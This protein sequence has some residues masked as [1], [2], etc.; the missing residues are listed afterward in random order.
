MIIEHYIRNAISILRQNTFKKHVNKS[1]FR[2]YR[3]VSSFKPPIYA[4]N[5]GWW[6][7]NGIFSQWT[8]SMCFDS[9]YTTPWIPSGFS[10]WF[11]SQESTW[12]RKRWQK[13]RDKNNKYLK[14]ILRADWSR[15]IQG[16]NHATHVKTDQR[17]NKQLPPAL[18]QSLMA[19]SCNGLYSNRVMFCLYKR[20]W[21]CLL[22]EASKGFMC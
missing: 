15:Y 1:L 2:F 7:S 9:F 10:T 3:C 5:L 17:T 20:N 13:K 18:M 4:N 19:F 14:V 12:H 22:F 11:F 16:R 6:M 21:T 8:Q